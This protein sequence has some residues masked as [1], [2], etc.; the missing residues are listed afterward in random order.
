MNKINKFLILVVIGLAFG[1]FYKTVDAARDFKINDV[2]TKGFTAEMVPHPG[3]DI[4]S[5][6]RFNSTTVAVI[7]TGKC[8]VYDIIISSGTAAVDYAIIRDSATANGSGS[9]IIGKFLSVSG[10]APTALAAGN[11][12]A[13]PFMTS[14]GI[15]VDQSAAG[16]FE[17][18]ILYKDM[19]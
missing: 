3:F 17:T 8:L 7:C 10:G 6:S 1:Y 12:N 18:L 15:T 9:E 4:K 14:L 11:P 5:Y 19:D 13:F 16:A 2:I